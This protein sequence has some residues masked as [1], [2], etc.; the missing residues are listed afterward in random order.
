MQLFLILRGLNKM[1]FKKLEEM[2]YSPYFNKSKKCRELFEILKPFY[3]NFN[4][5]LL[6][7]EAL[8]FQLYPEKKKFTST[9]HTIMSQLQDLAEEHLIQL[10]LNDRLLY[11]KHLLLKSHLKKGFHR[12]FSAQYKETMDRFANIKKRDSINFLEKYLI[13][14]DFYNYE[15][16]VKGRDKPPNPAAL[17]KNLDSF[18]WIQKLILACESE[19]FSNISS[20]VDSDKNE[21][22]KL[23]FEEEKSK[24]Q[25]NE[26]FTQDHLSLLFQSLLRCI[27]QPDDE[28]KFD[29]FLTLFL[30][31]DPRLVDKEEYNEF[32][33]H[34]IN[35]CIIK[36]IQGKGEYRNKLFDLYK[37][38]VDFELIYENGY[39]NLNR[40]KNIISCAAQVGELEWAES[41]LEN[42]KDTIHPDQLNSAYHFYLAV[43]YFYKEQFDDA[44]KYLSRIETDIDK[45]YSLNRT[46]FLIRCY[47]ENKS[48]FVFENTCKTFRA[49]LKRNKKLTT[50]EKQSFNAF[51][52]LAVFIHQYRNGLGSKTKQQLLELVNKANP[53]THKQW[54]LAKL[55]ELK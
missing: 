37:L 29:K 24:L 53:I 1:E 4:D 36:I 47:Y 52:R 13:E 40:V 9:F 26:N 23:S 31:T 50:K 18:F 8:F 35:Y 6:N 45:Y 55:E 48:R 21:L 39:L 22:I 5:S 51:T 42:Y 11:K 17:S 38:I 46:T 54:L 43:I 7:K 34:S 3:P 15:K 28:E 30:T 19:V 33:I 10:E 14:L 20:T 12:R 32:F 2:V 44:I 16:V 27:Q 49:N 25:L 41:F